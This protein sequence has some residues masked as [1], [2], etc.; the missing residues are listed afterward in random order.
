M[1]NNLALYISV[2]GKIVMKLC[3]TQAQLD[4][5]VLACHSSIKRNLK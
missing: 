4:T 5:E 2:P 3:G 1:H